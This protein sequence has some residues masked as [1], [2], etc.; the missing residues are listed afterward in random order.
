MKL[1]REFEQE[2]SKII[3][4]S[5]KKKNIGKRISRKKRNQAKEFDF[6]SRSNSP[7]NNDKSH[8]FKMFLM[9]NHKLDKRSKS[10]AKSQN[11]VKFNIVNTN[12]E[13]ELKNQMR[14]LEK[15][16]FK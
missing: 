5:L 6:D 14:M 4:H 13:I 16:L 8:Q 7:E 15:E 9:L 1:L 12:K 3:H 2:T 10:N 11:D